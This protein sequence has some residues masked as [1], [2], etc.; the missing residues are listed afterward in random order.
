MITK[1]SSIPIGR[2]YENILRRG[3]WGCYLQHKS[4]GDATVKLPYRKGKKKASFKSCLNYLGCINQQ[5]RLNPEEINQ[6]YL[7]LSKSNQ[8]VRVERY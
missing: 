4:E 8:M 7:S 2:N 6:E 3:T 5:L 1:R